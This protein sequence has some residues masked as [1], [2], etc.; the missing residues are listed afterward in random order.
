LQRGTS[1][2]R[3]LS[4][5]ERN[6]GSSLASNITRKSNNIRNTLARYGHIYTGNNQDGESNSKNGTT[7]GGDLNKR[8]QSHIGY[9]VNDA[10][11]I[12]HNREGHHVGGFVTT[13][14]RFGYPP[15][16]GTTLEEQRGPYIYVL[17]KVAQ[18]HYEEN[19][20]FYTVQREDTGEDIRG[21]PGEYCTIVT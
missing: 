21:D 4:L 19:A 3:S 1:F 2:R 17:G 8:M 5:V 20:K 11:L 6:D 18:V 9:S 15:A 12:I 13:V 7:P 10:V 16:S 14:N